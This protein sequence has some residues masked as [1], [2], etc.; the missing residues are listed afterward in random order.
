MV[1]IKFKSSRVNMSLVFILLHPRP[2]V[3]WS[4][5]HVLCPITDNVQN[6]LLVKSQKRLG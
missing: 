5:V 6:D 2:V 3:V 1:I 4:T